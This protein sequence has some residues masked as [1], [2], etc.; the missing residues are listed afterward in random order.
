MTY[1]L[2]QLAQLSTEQ[3]LLG[4]GDAR[5]TLD[6][7]TGVNKYGCGS[8]PDST[9]LAFG[10]S[11]G[12]TI[13]E[14]GFAAAHALQQRFS[15]RDNEQENSSSEVTLYRHELERIRLQFNQLCDFSI[16][17]DIASI[18]AASGTD[19]HLICAQLMAAHNEQPLHII[20]MDACETGS[21]VAPAVRGQHFSNHAALG[22]TV[23][24]FDT[25]TDAHP[26]EVT[27]IGLRDTN[28]KKRPLSDIDAEVE[29]LIQQAISQQQRVL[30]IMI[31]I[32]KTGLIAPSPSYITTLRQRYSDQVDVLIDACQF[33][34]ANPTL[35]AYLK[36]GCMV[37]LTGSKFLTG[38]V[39][40]GV[41]LIPPNLITRLSTQKLPASLAD[42]SAQAEW[43]ENWLAT[44]QL[45]NTVNWGLLLRLEA[46]LAELSAFRAIPE[47]EVNAFLLEFAGAMQQALQSSPHFSL[48]AE[49][50]LDRHPIYSRHCWDQ[51]PT[52][53]P[54]LLQHQAGQPITR[55]QTL[56]I[57][58]QLQFPIQAS[59]AETLSP[60]IA[61]LRCQLGQPVL[62]GT[63]HGIAVSALRMCASSRLI[64]DACAHG[65]ESRQQV[66]QQ[67]L[68]ALEKAEYLI[69]I[70]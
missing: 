63:Q 56:Q 31:D 11:T 70:L 19:L 27:S 18:F 44:E 23:T 5:L 41:L 10:S 50:R 38:P 26:V 62:C 36:L 54:F 1:N 7:Q 67:A 25:L 69:K 13:S 34:I 24:A 16:H 32:S 49:S 35:N 66:I 20:M 30:L 15:Q 43:P 17:T 33:R 2:A 58:K 51:I 6:P 42:Y 22:G 28:G 47:T 45:S 8:H 12:S 61:N 9:L 64:I 55:E 40:S 21:G 48:M 57:Y 29:D 46:A 4:G 3:A 68:N 37:T 39:F 52:I 60:A 14:R 65:A 59:E 53:F